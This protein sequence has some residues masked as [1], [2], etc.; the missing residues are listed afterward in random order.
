MNTVN[1]KTDPI[2]R[3]LVRALTKDQV[4]DLLTSVFDLFDDQK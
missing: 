3:E 4:A 2:G 1:Q